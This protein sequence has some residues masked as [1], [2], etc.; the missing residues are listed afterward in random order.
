VDQLRRASELLSASTSLASITPLLEFLG[1]DQPPLPLDD[2]TIR[3]LAFMPCISATSVARGTGCLRALIL[4]ATSPIGTRELVQHIAARLAAKVPHLH[5]VLITLNRDARELSIACW[6]NGRR[7][8]RVVALI[9]DQRRVLKSDSETLCALSAA[10]SGSDI[11]THVR[12]I[13]LLGRE[14]ITRRFFRALNEV[15]GNLASGLSSPIRS[16]D[17]RELSILCVSR[18][19]FLSFLETKGWLNSDFDFLANTFAR[20]AAGKGGYHRR[21]LQPLFFGTLNTRYSARAARAKEFGRIPFLNGG[22]FTRSHLERKL[23]G[24]FFGDDALAE[25]FTRL[26]T[27]FRFSAREDSQ[28]WSETAIDPE[29]LGKAFEALMA[30]DERKTSGAFYT[31]QRLVQHVTESALVA[32]LAPEVDH[33]VLRNLLSTGELPDPEIRAQLLARV[34]RLRILD[35]ACGSGAFLVH[36]LERLAEL[37]L[38]LGEIGTAS[39]IRRRSLTSSIFGVD[40]N[41]MAV[42][43]C[44]LRLWLAIVIDGADS[45]PMRI[46]PLP[47]LDRQ[48]RVGDSLSGGSFAADP[49]MG[50]GRKLAHLRARYIRAV[51]P[52]KKNLSRQLD[53]EERAEAIADL[54]RVR[55]KLHAERREILLAAR[56]KDLFGARSA[57]EGA[58]VDRLRALR[59]GERAAAERQRRL[60]AGAALPFAFNVHFADVESAGGFD[61][62]VGNPPWVR[63]HNI[64]ASMRRSLHR[65]FTTLRNC[66]WGGGVALSGSGRAFASQIDLAALFV[67]RSTS[68][69]RDKGAL[70]LLLPAKLWSSLSGGGVRELVRKKVELVAL[71]DMTESRSGFDAAVYPSLL[72]GRRSMTREPDPD[73]EFAAA[74]F[75]S[76]SAVQ[77]E[78][79]AGSLGLDDSPGSPW[80]LVPREVRRAFD[81][82]SAAGVPLAQSPLGRPLLGVK[83]G[84]NAAYIVEPNATSNGLAS[85]QSSGRSASIESRLLRAVLRGETITPWRFEPNGERILW[86]HAPDGKALTKLPPASEGWLRPWRP[87]LERRSDGRGSPRWWSLFRTDGAAFDRPRVVWG[88][89]GKSPR[90]L[91][92]DRGEDVVPLNTCYVVRCATREDALALTT[93]LNGPLMAAWLNTLAEPAR[94]G[95]RRYL[96]WTVSLMP[97]PRD[98]AHARAE[99]CAI[100]ERAFAGETPTQ[101]DLLLAALRAFRVRKASVEALLSWTN[102]S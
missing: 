74:V 93:L 79:K 92:L 101:H 60:E 71:E 12:W 24:A 75:R 77:W 40:I 59:A 73:A 26:L 35:P 52:R 14:A 62:V 34:E 86:T 56:T 97:L 100:G 76:G 94:G 91:V 11:L 37:R 18:L 50:R 72:V 58:T 99:L 13:E 33:A 19:L 7:P 3:E 25:I 41:P 5:W 102:R 28:A 85:V 84:C 9:A 96:G 48:I 23:S 47:N 15:V 63:I 32:A 30:A 89:F 98:W 1:F 22:L 53:R 88:D 43:L 68:L 39:V 80:L 44:Q 54:E 61:V 20:C 10:Q 64:S 8:P 81:A 45:D 87:V 36:A 49:A 17:R 55:R 42:W 16:A 82:L 90:A 70:A 31:P 57:S 65:S 2:A 95:Y 78:L 69:L 67:E 29:I 27:S 83:T 21:V 4:E 38:R 51:G 6:E 66:A 46:T